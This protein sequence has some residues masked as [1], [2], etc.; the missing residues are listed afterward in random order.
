LEKDFEIKIE[1][2]L[3]ISKEGGAIAPPFF[4]GQNSFRL[5]NWT[6]KA[7]R[8]DSSNGDRA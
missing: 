8:L 2:V 3:S 7:N 6:V 1:A 4:D 5:E